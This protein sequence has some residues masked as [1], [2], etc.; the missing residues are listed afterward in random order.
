MT[1]SRT[2]RWIGWGLNLVGWVFVLL[3]RYSIGPFAN[4]GRAIG[5]LPFFF[6]GGLAFSLIGLIKETKVKRLAEQH[7]AVQ[8]E[9][10]K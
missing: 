10:A 7:E 3:G 8:L 2:I 5:F 1:A 4:R 9:Q 6:F